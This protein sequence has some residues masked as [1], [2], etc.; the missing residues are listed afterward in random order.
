MSGAK[1]FTTTK[2]GEI[3]DLKEDLNSGRE[4][5]K[6]DAVKRIIAA[7]TEGKD[8]S[9]LFTDVVN[10]MQTRN[11]EL[12]KLVYLYVM[13]YA[14][15]QPDRAILAVN[16]FQ[17][18]ASD[19][20]PLIRALAVR[21]MGCIRV[22]RIVEYLTQPLSLC[23]KDSDP[24]VRKTAAV[25]V[26]KLFDINPEL[27]VAQGFLDQLKELIADPNPMVIANAVAALTEISEVSKTDVFKI[28][29]TN[30]LKLLAALNECTEWGQVF[31][32][33]SLAKYTPRDAHEAEMICERVTPRLNHTNSS[34]VLS[35]V[36]VVMLM[37]DHMSAPDVVSALCRKLSPPLVTLLSGAKQPE[38]HYVALRNINIIIQKRPEIL[39][40]DVRVFVCKYNDPIYVKME[41]LDIMIMLASERN[42]DQILPEFKEYATMVDVEFVRKSV[43]AIGRCA[44]KLEPC[45]DR[46][47]QALLDLIQTKVNYVV[48]EAVIVIKDIFRKYPN[49]YEGII[50]TLCE[51]LDSLDEPEAKASMVWI[52]GEYAE[53]IDNADQ[54]LA[55]FTDSFADETPQVQL[56]LLTATVKLFLRRP[57]TTQEMVQR[58]LNTATQSDNPDLRDRGFVY[59]RLLSTDPEA[60][61]GVILSEKPR[62]NDT[63]VSLHEPLLSELMG[64][65]ATLASVYH[66]PPEAFVSKSRAQ[67]KPFKL[68]EDDDEEQEYDTTPEQPVVTQGTGTT[69]STGSSTTTT[70]TAPVSGAKSVLD[71]LDLGTTSTPS[72]PTP[73]TQVP[74]KSTSLLEN[75]FF[76]QAA[77]P[78]V[79]KEV[80]L[81]AA[82]AGGMELKGAFTRR[83]KQV[84]LDLTVVNVSST[85]AISQLAVQFNKNSFGLTPAAQPAMPTTAFLGQSVD[86][87][88][89]I[90]FNGP[91]TPPPLSN[92][93]Q[94]AIKNNAN[95]V[96]YF[97]LEVPISVLLVETGTVDQNA[98][99]GAWRQIPNS[100]EVVRQLP[101]PPQPNWFSAIMPAKFRAS[102]IFEVARFKMENDDMMYLSMRLVDGTIVFMECTATPGA[103]S[104]TVSVRS[105]N[106]AAAQLVAASLMNLLR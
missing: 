16:T 8:V 5:R 99:V 63:T 25:C 56:Q 92:S 78:V 82:K 88:L 36:K 89:P 45:A 42:I 87:S 90:A 69:P 71:L 31:L 33:D 15:S 73:V 14:K 17:R 46:C 101:M 37:I 28:D 58:V 83:D 85:V 77:Q 51:N 22:D 76:S 57:K 35:A 95:V 49:R 72:T 3:H 91:T 66:K 1:Y 102:N 41:K 13:N 50:A 38:I 21:T 54:L 20:N 79:V 105:T 106:A 67:A 9:V 104:C 30:L 24:Y 34:V 93:I 26:A 44:I 7:M 23:L 81:P 75:E 39:Q 19:P 12:K 74:P 64:H 11:V 6:V 97:V 96:Y 48:Q 80:I 59:W 84:F 27:V 94:V 62:I 98:F 18:D 100:S 2:K 32:L 52:I 65:I 61:K 47:I 10:C 43:R 70:Q 68:H 29:A 4:D 53:R 40:N 103:T 55:A 86:V 60:A